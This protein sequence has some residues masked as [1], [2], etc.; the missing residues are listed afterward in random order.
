[1]VALTITCRPIAAMGFRVM[2]MAVSMD[3]TKVP[4]IYVVQTSLDEDIEIIMFEEVDD[5]IDEIYDL[6]DLT[7]FLV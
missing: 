1:M 6:Y 7:V 5:M 3:D 4:V 2:A